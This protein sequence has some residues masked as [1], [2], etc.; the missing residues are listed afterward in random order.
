MDEQ[1]FLSL[2]NFILI[3]FLVDEHIFFIWS[4]VLQWN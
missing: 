2:I 4:G 1:K 3:A